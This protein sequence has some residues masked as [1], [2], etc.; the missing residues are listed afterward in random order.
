MNDQD[1]TKTFFHAFN[2]DFKT[3]QIGDRIYTSVFIDLFP[4]DVQQFIQLF[5]RTL[6]THIPWRISFMMDGGGLSTLK[7]KSALAGVLAFSSA[8][9]RL[10]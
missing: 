8:Q 7:L 10:G 2:I 6:Q 1:G 3:A 9:N 5:A 4:K